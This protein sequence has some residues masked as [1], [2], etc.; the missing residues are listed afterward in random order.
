MKRLASD[1]LT[2]PLAAALRMEI[3]YVHN[4]ATGSHDATEGLI[5]FAEKRKPRFPAADRESS[6]YHPQPLTPR[7]TLIK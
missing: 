1:A 2:M 5:A 4:Y 7:E 3:D 6:R